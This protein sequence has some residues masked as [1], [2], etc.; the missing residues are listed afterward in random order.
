MIDKTKNPSWKVDTVIHLITRF[1]TS[2]ADFNQTLL[3]CMYSKDII[4]LLYE[5][6]SIGNKIS[7]L[8]FFEYL[9]L[10]DRCRTKF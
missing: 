6:I 2:K 5:K 3:F 9:S 10:A 1:M 7:E 4:F 8:A